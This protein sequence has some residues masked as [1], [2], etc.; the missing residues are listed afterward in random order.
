MNDLKFAYRQLLKNLWFSGALLLTVALGVGAATAVF[1]AIDLMVLH[2]LPGPAAGRLVL[3]GEHQGDSYV[4]MSALAAL[5]AS[6]SFFSDFAWADRLV[7]Q[8]KGRGRFARRISGEMVSPNFFTLWGVR[9]LLGRTFAKGEGLILN[10]SG[11]PVSD[12]VIVLSYPAWQSLCGGDPKVIGRR[13]RLGGRDLAIVGVMPRYFRI[14]WGGALF[15]VPVRG[16]PTVPTFHPSLG[17]WGA[18]PSIQA[19]GLLKP[20]VSQQAT[21]AL[22]D[23]LMPRIVRTE[24][25]ARDLARLTEPEWERHFDM[26]R[27]EMR[28][29]RSV[30][31]GAHPDQAEQGFSVRLARSLFAQ[32]QAGYIRVLGRLLGII[33]LVLL[34]AY[35][36]LATQT[37]AQSEKR[38]HEYAVRAAIGAGR[39]RLVRQLLTEHALSGAIAGLLALPVAYAVLKL[40]GAQIPPWGLQCAVPIQLNGSLMAVC[41]LISVGVGLAFGLVPAWYASRTDVGQTLKQGASQVTGGRKWGR[42]RE[43]VVVTQ[44]ALAFALLT[45]AGLMAESVVRLLAVKPPF[46]ERNLLQMKVVLPVRIGTK[47][48][49]ASRPNHA[50]DDQSI[51]PRFAVLEERLASVPGVQALGV[52]S[53]GGGSS[54]YEIEGEAAQVKLWYLQCGF[55]KT[56]LLRALRIPLLAGRYLQTGDRSPADTGVIINQAMARL[57]WPGRNPLGGVFRGHTREGGVRLYTVV[58]VASHAVFMWSHVAGF[59]E[60]VSPTYAD[61]YRLV[62]V[63]TKGD[64]LRVIPSLYRTMAAAE[65]GMNRPLI[66]DMQQANYDSTSV[67]RAYMLWLLISGAVGLILVVVGIYSVLALSV[68]RRT[69]EIGLR[70]ALGARPRDI[71]TA[72]ISRGARLIALGILAGLVASFWLTRMLRHELFGTSPLN[73]IVWVGA[74]LL[75]LGVGLFACYLPARRAAKVNPMEALRYE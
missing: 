51:P 63:R 43:V 73:P 49:A 57:C 40:I 34:I 5:E 18:S 27:A 17:T 6:R 3:I 71:M 38:R 37:L 72:I 25:S 30:G 65:P 28:A 7:L 44:V 69:R 10:G 16:L 41:V 45:G 61:P 9:P 74:V 67:Q 60:P 62:F 24:R 50:R 39:R 32:S 33:G 13:I 21:Q 68:V 66:E 42:Y 46:D 22:L 55:G 8:Y 64:P 36:N 47:A 1:S 15:W 52:W 26:M 23:E 2:P 4:S 12:T 48:G 58:G 29:G 75:L 35:L 20:G 56:D 31:R 19:F 59:Y 70:L 14:P 11:T 53:R 54:S